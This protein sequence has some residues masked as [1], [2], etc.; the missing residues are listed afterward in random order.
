MWVMSEASRLLI[1]EMMERLGEKADLVTDDQKGETAF[2]PGP[3]EVNLRIP[4]VVADPFLAGDRGVGI[5][6]RPSMILGV[7]D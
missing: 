6:V 3:R 4:H 5:E 1:D 2:L 7:S